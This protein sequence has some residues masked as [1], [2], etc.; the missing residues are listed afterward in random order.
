MSLDKGDR[1]IQKR[2]GRQV[3][4]LDPDYEDG[5]V[6]FYYVDHGPSDWFYCTVEEVV[7]FNG[8]ERAG[9]GL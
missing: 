7:V 8:Y 9:V 3:V 5:M 1:F 2:S 6:S 4:V